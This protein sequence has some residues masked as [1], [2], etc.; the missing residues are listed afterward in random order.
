MSEP[1]QPCIRGCSRMCRCPECGDEPTHEP[2]PIRAA[3][4]SLMCA[5]C[6][7]RLHGWLSSVVDDTLHLDAR[8]PDDYSYDKE[9]GHHKVSGSPALVRLD[10]V[11]LT[12]RR[13]NPT[14]TRRTQYYEEN[15]QDI[16][17][18][19]PEQI[20]CW[21]RLFAEE[22]GLSSPYATL[23]QAVSLLTIWWTTL[24]QQPWVDDL[25]T[26][27]QE[28]RQILDR[29]HG[30]EKPKPMGDCFTCAKPLYSRPGESTIQC[31]GC[32]RRYDGLAI[33]RL[34]V[35]RRREA[36]MTEQAG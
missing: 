31:K 14:V 34:E 19:I 15:Q 25:Y 9:S 22:Q 33:V 17:Y 27:M 8:I 11:A 21:A 28:I 18:S 16:G 23:A 7:D 1:T 5:R 4:P 10:V 12:D 26:D 30:V 32:G 36:D 2:I 35:Q 3:D 29:A 24:I 20:S 6:T 13:T